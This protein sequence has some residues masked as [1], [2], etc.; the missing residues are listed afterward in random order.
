MAICFITFGL[1]CIQLLLDYIEK[2]MIWLNRSKCHFQSQKGQLGPFSN[3]FQ[4]CAV[5]RYVIVLSVWS[6]I[7]TLRAVSCSW[8]L[9]IQPNT[10]ECVYLRFYAHSSW[11]DVSCM[12]STNVE[13]MCRLWHR[14]L[15][16]Y[17]LLLRWIRQIICQCK[18]R[19]H[20]ACEVNTYILHWKKVFTSTKVNICFSIFLT[21]INFIC[22]C[23]V[24]SSSTETLLQ[25]DKIS[26][27]LYDIPVLICRDI[28]LD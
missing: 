9:I 26:K 21:N 19:I 15:Y 16:K 3:N 4:Y 7:C 1:C 28:K 5:S 23:R 25:V 11:T 10:V 22:S 18:I 14:I 27:R 20:R 6:C 24:T 12:H 2:D 8:R 13:Y 17:F